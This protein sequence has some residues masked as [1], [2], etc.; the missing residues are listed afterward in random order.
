MLRKKIA[1]LQWAFLGMLISSHSKIWGYEFRLNLRPSGSV[2]PSEH[3]RLF[4]PNHIAGEHPELLV[5]LHG[6]LQSAEEFEKG[7]QLN[8]IAERLGFL[9]FYPQQKPLRDPLGCWQWFE[10]S[11]QRADSGEPDEIMKK[12]EIV[13]RN[14]SVGKVFL[15][16]ISSG[17]A[18][19]SILLAC[20]PRYFSGGAI[21]S[22]IPY[23]IVKNRQEGT[24]VMRSGPM[25]AK[26]KNNE[27]CNAQS[28]EG[29]VMVIHGLDDEVVHIENS[30]RIQ[31]D[32]SRQYDFSEERTIEASADRYSYRYRDFYFANQLRSRLILVDGL[33]HA[34]SGGD[35]HLPFNDERGPSAGALM[36]EFF[37][38]N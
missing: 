22:G 12:I 36:W 26:G 21:H 10:P 2:Q 35:G 17:G 16:G 30:R 3:D 13:K 24:E 14:Y 32:F 37:H 7:A 20:Y 8:S 31:D 29:R 33:G 5:A 28:F 34:W 4:I 27:E 19:T 6:C 9:V 11:N 18:M 15:T 25:A 1:F 38:L 23:G